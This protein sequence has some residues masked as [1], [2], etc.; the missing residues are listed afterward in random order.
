MINLN[1]RAP[2]VLGA[3]RALMTLT[4]IKQPNSLSLSLA[5]CISFHML[6]LL[7]LILRTLCTL[8]TLRTLC[9]LCTLCTLRIS[10]V[11]GV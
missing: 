10:P 9:T 8:R 5:S 1:I 2:Q 3:L 6:I 11:C 7:V 4:G